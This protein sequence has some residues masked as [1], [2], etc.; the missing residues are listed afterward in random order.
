[1]YPPTQYLRNGIIEPGESCD[2]TAWGPI[3][4]CWDLD[5]FRVE[6]TCG[7]NCPST[8]IAALRRNARMDLTTMAMVR[9]IR[10]MRSALDRP[11]R[12]NP[13]SVVMARV[14]AAKHATLALRTVHVLLRV[15]RRV[16]RTL[17]VAAVV[18]A[19]AAVVAAVVDTRHHQVLRP[20]Q[21]TLKRVRQE[22]GYRLDVG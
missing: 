5:T 18:E 10:M 9:T 4:T 22:L 14:K 8:R 15:P 21:A 3:D 6:V 16:P 13:Q 12:A 1:M 17:V 7:T 11:T 20:V 19:V 2:G